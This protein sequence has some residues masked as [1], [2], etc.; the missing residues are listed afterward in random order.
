[1]EPEEADKVIGEKYDKK[2]KHQDHHTGEFH[3][4]LSFL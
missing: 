2:R 4:L 3:Q 1:M